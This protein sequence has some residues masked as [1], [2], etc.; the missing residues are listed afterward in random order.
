M[1]LQDP[2]EGTGCERQ[3]VC[4]CPDYICSAFTATL[5]L[6]RSFHPFA[7]LPAQQQMALFC[8]LQK[9]LFDEELLRALEQVVGGWGDVMDLGLYVVALKYAQARPLRTALG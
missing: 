4:V 3:V 7:V 1:Y 8:I 2:L 9:I 6:D 5:H